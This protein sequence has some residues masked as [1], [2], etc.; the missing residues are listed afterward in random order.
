[1]EGL[2]GEWIRRIIMLI[3][4]MINRRLHYVMATTDILTVKFIAWCCLPN[5]VNGCNR[6]Y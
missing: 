6:W 4:D 2:Y 5:I 1:M 3:T